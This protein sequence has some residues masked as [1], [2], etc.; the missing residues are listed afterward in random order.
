M[1]LPPSRASAA[2]RPEVMMARQIEF[3]F[4]YGSPFSYLAD[5]QL[6]ALAKRTG[7][8]IVYRPML[9]GAVF[10]ATSNA[11]PVTVPAKGR[12][13]GAELQR[14]ARRYG[15][16]MDMNS[17]FP[18]N[19]IKLMRAAVAA[20]MQGR[21]AQYHPAAFRAVWVEGI[22]GSDPAA[23]GA[24]LERTGL[25]RDSI[26]GGEIKDRLRANTDEA[27]A[28]GV[29]G[30][31]TFFVGDDMFWGNDRLDFVEEALTRAA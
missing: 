25:A 21:F 10:K 13:M 11:S 2:A 19:T 7:A 9:L 23:L 27:V 31:P 5:T 4:D 8:E 1:K 28:R 29:F 6:P 17:H 12:Y 24:L 3:F 18:F 26:E 15:V 20:Q 14:W 16:P 30:A 22:D